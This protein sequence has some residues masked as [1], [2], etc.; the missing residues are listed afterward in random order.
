MSLSFWQPS[1]F[2]IG[3]FVWVSCGCIVVLIFISREPI[4]ASTARYH[5]AP[6]APK[7]IPVATFSVSVERVHSHLKSLKRRRKA[8]KLKP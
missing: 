8:I 4:T 1:S 2:T 3:V 6:P 7:A 5:V